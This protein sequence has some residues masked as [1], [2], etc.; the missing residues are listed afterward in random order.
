[1]TRPLIFLTHAE[2]AVD[3]DVPVPG[4]GLSESGRARHHRFSIDPA[5]KDITAIY[6]SAERKACEGAA[7]HG[8]ALGLVPVV[9]SALHENDRSATG[10]LPA[11]EFEATAD[12]FFA[13][14]D[15]SVRGWET[16]RA[17]EARIV[18][19]LRTVGE[20]DATGGGLL[21]VSHGAVGAL[22]RCHLKGR[23]ISRDEDQPAGGGCWYAT[24]TRL[25]QAP[26]NWR[27]I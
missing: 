10:Y 7:I 11:E 14:A 26:Q 15:S 18:A 19:A 25:E 3:P 6:S 24:D 20:L 2:V 27:R 5:L 17:A 21:I 8:E 13:A 1:M 23:E 22:M 16:A 9:V 4:W 12:A